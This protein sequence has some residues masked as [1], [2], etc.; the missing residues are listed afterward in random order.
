M[1]VRGTA[2]RPSAIIAMSSAVSC[3][4]PET[5]RGYFGVEGLFMDQGSTTRAQSFGDAAPPQVLAH[6]R[7]F[8]ILFALAFFGVFLFRFI[9]S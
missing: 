1:A 3:F 6:E 5:A 8:A 7:G 4:F 9:F 2:R